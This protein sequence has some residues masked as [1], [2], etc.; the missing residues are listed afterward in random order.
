MFHETLAKSPDLAVAVAAIKALTTVIRNSG[1]Q[2]LM[3]LGKDLE[4]AAQALQRCG[5]SIVG[6]P[7]VVWMCCDG[8]G[9]GQADGG[10]AADGEV[11]AVSRCT[12]R[13]VVV[14]MQGEHYNPKP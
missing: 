7:V 11:V 14:M 5:A 8:H 9:G 12:G 4:D 3:G 6:M 1:A 13:P 2:T 10:A